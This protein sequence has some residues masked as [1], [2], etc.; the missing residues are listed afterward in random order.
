MIE[1]H[2]T[3]RNEITSRLRLQFPNLF[4]GRAGLG[5]NIDFGTIAGEIAGTEGNVP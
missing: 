5:I 4:K 3:A 1:A 2:P